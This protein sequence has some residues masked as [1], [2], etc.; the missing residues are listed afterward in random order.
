VVIENFTRIANN[1]SLPLAIGQIV[2]VRHQIRVNQKAWRSIVLP[3][4]LSCCLGGGEEL[5]A[6]HGKPKPIKPIKN[7]LLV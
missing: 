6:C 7:S 3:K 1:K 2:E 5:A 4:P